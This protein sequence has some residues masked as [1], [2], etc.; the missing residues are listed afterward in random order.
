MKSR[1]LLAALL[2]LLGLSAPSA[3]LSLMGIGGADLGT[4]AP[5]TGAL[6]LEDGSSILLLEGG[7]GNLCLEGGC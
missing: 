5:T 6:L 7:A 4:A 2:L 1:L 3:Q